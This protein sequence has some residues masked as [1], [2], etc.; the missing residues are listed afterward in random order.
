MIT[1][2]RMDD[3]QDIDNQEYE[4]LNQFSMN[5]MKVI[6]NFNFLNHKRFF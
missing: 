2:E 6:V 4:A 5:S 1:Q 3:R